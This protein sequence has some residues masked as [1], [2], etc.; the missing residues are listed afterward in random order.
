MTDVGASAANEVCN[1]LGLRDTGFIIEE[2]TVGNVGVEV[3]D[4][5]LASKISAPAADPATDVPGGR[6]N[7]SDPTYASSFKESV[8][9]EIF[10]DTIDDADECIDIEE[11]E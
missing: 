7:I 9:R 5:L 6:E 4:N 2:A 8:D 3:E 10:S 1:E 11:D